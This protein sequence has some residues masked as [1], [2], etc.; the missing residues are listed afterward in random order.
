MVTEPVLVHP[1]TTGKPW[2]RSHLKASRTDSEQ[3]SSHGTH[4]S[5]SIITEDQIPDENARFSEQ[6]KAGEYL[7]SRT[8]AG[9]MRAARPG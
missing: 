9:I 6:L 5:S 4:Q 1:L 8:V 2:A 3:Y 7:R